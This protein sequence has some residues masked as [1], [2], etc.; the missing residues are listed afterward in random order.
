M[1]VLWRGQLLAYLE[2]GGR[3]VLTWDAPEQ[4]QLDPTDPWDAAAR[5]VAALVTHGHVDTLTIKTLDGVSALST[6][7]AFKDALLGHG[8]HISPQGLRKRR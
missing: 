6:E 7:S 8:F 1:V 4:N 5:A 3:T 2:R